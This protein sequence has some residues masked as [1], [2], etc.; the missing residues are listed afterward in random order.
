MSRPLACLIVLLLNCA[1]Q[2]TAQSPDSDCAIYESVINQFPDCTNSQLWCRHGQQLL[3]R[4][5]TVV[6]GKYQLISA[7][8]RRSRRYLFSYR[9]A[10]SFY[11]QPDTEQ[12]LQS[13]PRARWATGVV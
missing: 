8:F 13:L 4:R 12:V 9:P 3:I 5:T 6:P 11:K 10:D 7:L 1:W 2:Y